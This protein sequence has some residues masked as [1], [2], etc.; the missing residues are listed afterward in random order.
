MSGKLLTIGIFIIVRVAFFA[1]P[2]VVLLLFGADPWISAVLSAVM[3]FALS[4]IFLEKL[5]NP[6]MEGLL[7]RRLA[8]TAAPDVDAEYEDA[9]L[10]GLEEQDS[11]ASEHKE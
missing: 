9:L 2:L 10:D 6:L 4:I 3:G 5:K 1:V 11:A 7:E 8:E